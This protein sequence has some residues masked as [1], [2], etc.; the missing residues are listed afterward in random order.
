[1]GIQPMMR[2][3]W[4]RERLLKPCQLD[5]AGIENDYGRYRHSWMMA[6]E[7]G[8]TW[9]SPVLR[10]SFNNHDVFSAMEEY[11]LLNDIHGSLEAKV[12]KADVLDKLKNSLLIRL[13]GRNAAEQTEAM[14][15]LPVPS[16]VHYTEYLHGGFDKQYPDHLPVR[17]S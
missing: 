4:D 3:P 10:L 17:E 12:R 5:L 8:E 11:A 13:G 15:A 1:M 9:S 16:L 14:K 2:K 7:A 6:C